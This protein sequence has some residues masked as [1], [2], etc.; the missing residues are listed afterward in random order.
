[1]CYYTQG[2]VGLRIHELLYLF[3]VGS[4]DELGA[5]VKVLPGRLLQVQHQRVVADLQVVLSVRRLNQIIAIVFKPIRTSE[6]ILF[7]LLA[8]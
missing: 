1:M 5:E 8:W 3:H 7:G 6:V 2:Y 4:P